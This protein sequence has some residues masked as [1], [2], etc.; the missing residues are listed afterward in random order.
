MQNTFF[1]DVKVEV[2]MSD[3]IHGQKV[4]TFKEHD[5]TTWGDNYKTT[6][7]FGNIHAVEY[8]DAGVLSFEAI[9]GDED[10]KLLMLKLNNETRHIVDN[11]DVIDAIELF[12]LIEKYGGV[13][14]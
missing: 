1:E 8:H 9:E 6:H 2:I 10:R 12:S 4:Y 3:A 14:L 11:L 5:G 7:L 13:E